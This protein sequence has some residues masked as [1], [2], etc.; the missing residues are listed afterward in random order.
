MFVVMIRTVI[1][2]ALVFI[3]MRLM[4][5]R[6]IG[7]LQPFEL[8]V[9]LMISALAAVSM[10]D[11]SIPLINSIIPIIL[12]MSMQIIVSI[13]SLKFKKTRPVICGKPSVVIKNGRIV[14]QEL[15][16]LR[17]NL[18]DL[19]EQLRI[20]G[21][22]NI[23]DVEFAIMETNGNISVLPKSQKRPVTAEDLN[24]DTEYEG[25]CHSLVVDGEVERDN[26]RDMGLTE[27]WLKNELS[28]FGITDLRKVFFAS[29]DTTG[30]LFFQ[31]KE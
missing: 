26:I 21:Y 6:Q 25:I 30:K 5:K 7:E 9:A 1:L 3:V 13:I 15:K 2:Y 23:A 22:F 20:A 11:I 19:L 14:Q 27:D 12:I 8:A 10:E 4:G 29:L 31:L 18:H 16:N 24:L 17:I 28:K